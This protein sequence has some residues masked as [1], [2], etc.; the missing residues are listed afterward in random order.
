MTKR[1]TVLIDSA[2]AAQVD[3]Y[4]ETYRAQQGRPRRANVA[5]PR[6]VI[7]GSIAAYLSRETKRLKRAERG[8]E[9]SRKR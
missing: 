4:V 9:H 3:A 1:I 6:G 8:D 2:E 5:A 7:R